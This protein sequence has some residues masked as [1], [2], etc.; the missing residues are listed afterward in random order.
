MQI[1]LLRKSNNLDLNGICCLAVS[2]SRGH[3]CKLP[4]KELKRVYMMSVNILPIRVALIDPR[5]WL[6]IK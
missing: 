4:K 5:M 1:E 3:L 6:I 2:H